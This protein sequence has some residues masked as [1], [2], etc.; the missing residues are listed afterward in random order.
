MKAFRCLCLLMLSAVAGCTPSFQYF[1]HPETQRYQGY[2]EPEL[3]ADVF[4]KDPGLADSGILI[5]PGVGALAG[6][7]DHR[8]S[9]F[10]YSRKPTR[11]KIDRVVISRDRPEDSSTL[12]IHGTLEISSIDKH[13]GLFRGVV[14]VV[15]EGVEGASQVLAS[16]RVTMAIHYRIPSSQGRGEKRFILTRKVKIGKAFSDILAAA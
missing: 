7:P 3:P 11:I 10:I 4:K 12:D 13:S 16:R 8:A 2:W 5:L 6:E 15:F 9:I 14:P 1:E